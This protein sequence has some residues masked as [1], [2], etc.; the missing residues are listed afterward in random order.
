MTTPPD[1]AMM[2]D[3]DARV[4]FESLPERRR[5]RYLEPI[6]QARRPETREH[7]IARAIRMLREERS[8]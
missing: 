1:L 8:R 3:P 7:R 5:R 6:L 2:L 4:A